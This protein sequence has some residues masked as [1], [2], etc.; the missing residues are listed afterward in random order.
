MT[1]VARL[2]GKNQGSGFGVQENQLTAV[3]FSP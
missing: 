1:R 2:T 3:D